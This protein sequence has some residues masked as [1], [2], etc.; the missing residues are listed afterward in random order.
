[1][2]SLSWPF[3]QG[4]SSYSNSPLS[5]A[6]EERPLLPHTHPPP[7]SGFPRTNS[8]LPSGLTPS[9]PL[10]PPPP[11]L[12][13][14][15]AIPGAPSRGNPE[16]RKEKGR[17]RGSRLSGILPDA[18]E[19]PESA[20]QRLPLPAPPAQR[21]SRG[22]ARPFHVPADPPPPGPR[23]LSGLGQSPA[24][25]AKGCEIVLQA[26]PTASQDTRRRPQC[27]PRPGWDA[28]ADGPGRSSKA[29][30]RPR[31]ARRGGNA[32][33]RLSQR[34]A[35]GDPSHSALGRLG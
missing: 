2:W 33:G 6:W 26:P 32:S 3:P 30:H 10:P 12:F 13:P 25:A 8:S 9:R 19:P 29:G 14:G 5:G 21:C 35:P 1:M 16:E 28:P 20:K 18:S 15:L 27:R 23:T 7:R 34:R 24:S 11:P 22:R 17:R 31:P 4:V